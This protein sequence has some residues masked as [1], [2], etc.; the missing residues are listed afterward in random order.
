[1]YKYICT[2]VY[3]CI[4]VYVYKC[5]CVYVCVFVFVPTITQT[6][7]YTLW[8]SIM[9]SREIRELNGGVR[10]QQA[11]FDKPDVDHFLKRN[12]LYK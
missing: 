12:I 6:L 2:Y 4:S 8:Q 7:I 1:M 9:A 10:F 5:I 3:M 11:M